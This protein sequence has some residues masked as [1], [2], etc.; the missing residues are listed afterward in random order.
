VAEQAPRVVFGDA[1]DERV[2]SAVTRL[3]AEG[4]VRPVLVDPPVGAR[5]PSGVET[6]SLDDPVWVGRCAEELAAMRGSDDGVREALRDP[7][8]LAAVYTRLGGADAG[9]AG[10][11]S[12]SASVIR[13]GLRG[14]GLLEQDG[15]VTGCFVL[16][17]PGATRTYAD[18]S[19]IPS[20]DAGQLAVIA[21]SA[22]DWHR[23]VTGDEPRVALLSFST[24]GSAEHA[25]VDKV[26]EAV[27]IVRRRRP[28][29]V[30]DGELQ[31]DVAVTPEVAARKCPE[32]EVAGRANVLV[33]PD[34]GAGNIAYKVTERLAGARAVGS[35]VLGLRRPWVDLSRG[36]SADDVVDAATTLAELRTD[37]LVAGR[38][39][40]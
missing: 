12:T 4:V 10:S 7:L 13:A 23:R 37:S 22:A 6:L 36:C 32:S 15:L 11:V 39:G 8:L 38:G 17:L 18:V 2:V 30:V 27:A 34:L 33:F 20:P 24:L 31:F 5:V 28:D 16:H 14:L 35:F 25:D 40:A 19:V 9:V 3:S 1:H 29:L 26:R 21:A